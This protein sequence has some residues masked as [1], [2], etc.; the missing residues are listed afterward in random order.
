MKL[1]KT[2]KTIIACG[3]FLFVCVFVS[4]KAHATSVVSG[5]LPYIVPNFKS[6]NTAIS[7]SLLD[8]SY[9]KLLDT[10]IVQSDDTV[11]FFVTD[12]RS[13]LG[14]YEWNELYYIC[15]PVVQT[16]VTGE[17]NFLDT[18]ITLSCEYYGQIEFK[19]NN[20]FRSVGQT[21]ANVSLLGNSST[22][23]IAQGS[24]TP[25]YPFCLVGDDI[26]YGDIVVFTNTVN[27]G[28][29]Q[30][31]GHATAPEFDTSFIGQ[32]ADFG[33]SISN[34]TM[35]NT[36]TVNNYTWNTYNPPSVD[37]SSLENL[38]KSLI[39]IVKYNAT[40]ITE[41]IQGTLS[42]IIANIQAY[43]QYIG[44][45]IAYV[46]KSIITNIQNG[47][48]NLY[49]N[50]QSLIEPIFQ[51]LE[52]VKEKVDYITEE[53]SQEEWEENYSNCELISAYDN[54]QDNCEEIRDI[55]TYAEEREYY[56]LY[57]TFPKPDGTNVESMISFDWLYPLRSSY[58]P[59]LW[60][61]VLVELFVTACSLLGS[62]LGGK[63]K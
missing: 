22:I 33:A 62:V 6:V 34:S 47:I 37:T 50:F 60:V 36:P 1:N 32:G 54:I 39:D 21:Y 3:G 2:L 14:E 48:Q 15:N 46:G 23:E 58:R 30:I 19:W 25:R 10:N 42:T 43:G 12:L 38:V 55:L 17:Y 40:Y 56:H 45:I 29:V 63:A 51:I 41:G 4:F 11:L 52:I 49:E 8:A 7:D 13:N 26:K 27:Q 35:P 61:I 18:N 16:N 31:E 20:T 5:E 59:F 24:Y 44:D 28:P 53:F 57:L 9:Q